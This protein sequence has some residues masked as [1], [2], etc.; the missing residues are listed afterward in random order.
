MTGKI[1]I[2]FTNN[3]RQISSQDSLGKQQGQDRSSVFILVENGNMLLFTPRPVWRRG[4]LRRRGLRRHRLWVKPHAAGLTAAGSD[5]L[6]ARWAIFCPPGD[7]YSHDV[8]PGH[9]TDN[10][11]YAGDGFA[12][13][14][15][16]GEPLLIAQGMSSKVMEIKVSGFR[17]AGV[18][19]Y[20][21]PACP[22]SVTV[23]PFNPDDNTLAISG[24]ICLS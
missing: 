24:S 22:Y 6:K 10:P 21:E 3:I 16:G 8:R 13:T 18:L 1:N 12:D 19:L 23:P 2:K 11:R 9:L 17:S 7:S 20:S 15:V 14:Q 4:A 5:R